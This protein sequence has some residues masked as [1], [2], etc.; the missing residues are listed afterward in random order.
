MTEKDKGAFA[1]AVRGTVWNFD[2]NDLVIIGKDTDDG[3]DHNLYDPRIKLKL[4]ESMILSIMAQGVLE[5]VTVAGIDGKPVVVD[6]RR[7]VLHAREALARMR[8]AD[9]D[10]VLRVPASFRKDT[11]A[12]LFATMIVANSHRLNDDAVAEARKAEIM[13][14]RHN[15]SDEDIA[16]AFGW[17]TQTVRNR[18]KLLTLPAKVLRKVSS[19]EISVTAVME[20]AKMEPEDAEA[21]AEKVAEES[22]GSTHGQARRARAA[23]NPDAEPTIGKRQ[24]KAILESEHAE[25][26]SD[27]TR[28]TLSWIIG[29]TKAVAIKGLSACIKAVQK[30]KDEKRAEGRPKA[31]TNRATPEDGQAAAAK[32]KAEEKAAKRSRKGKKAPDV[33]AEA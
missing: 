29:E 24:I 6:G 18:R 26:L 11:D 28:R 12:G 19:G 30:A 9:K 17:T 16:K 25:D 23:A 7:R 4:S 22:G 10:A 27:D 1:N 31:P 14:E 3:P 15:A 5:N 13:K 21:A 32:A 33:I 20:L 2:P 8:K